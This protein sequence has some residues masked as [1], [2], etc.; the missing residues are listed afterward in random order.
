MVTTKD[1]FKAIL[2]YKGIDHKKLASIMGMSEQYTRQMLSR[3]DKCPN[4]I[5]LVVHLFEKSLD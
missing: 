2:K 5:K 4:Y 1:K 3:S